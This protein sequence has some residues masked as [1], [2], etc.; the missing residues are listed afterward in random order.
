MHRHRLDA[1]LQRPVLSS[2]AARGQRAHRVSCVHGEHRV[3]GASGRVERERAGTRRGESVPDGHTTGGAGIVRLAC[4][5]GCVLIRARDVTGRAGEHRRA[6][7]PVVRHRRVHRMPLR[8]VSD[9][10]SKEYCVPARPSGPR[11]RPSRTRDRRHR[12][13]RYCT[14]RVLEHDAPGRLADDRLEGEWV[15]WIRTGARPPTPRRTPGWVRS[16]SSGS[17]PLPA[18]WG[19][20]RPR[21]ARRIRPADRGPGSPSC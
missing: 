11:S 21:T 6:R 17:R 14:V 1:A 9:G 10:V 16:R 8:S 7:E 15:R 4:F 2:S 5:L 20:G 19:R 3:E 13:S 18:S 12:G